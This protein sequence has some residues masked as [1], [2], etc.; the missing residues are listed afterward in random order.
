MQYNTVSGLTTC[1][2]VRNLQ[3]PDALGRQLCPLLLFQQ[4]K[5]FLVLYNW[6]DNLEF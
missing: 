2:H 5:H 4:D 6:F 1:P 3:H